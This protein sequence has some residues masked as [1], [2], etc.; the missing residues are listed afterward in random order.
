MVVRHP[1][2]VLIHFTIASVPP[3]L[4]SISRRVSCVTCDLLSESHNTRLQRK[5]INENKKEIDLKE[6]EVDEETGGSGV[7]DS[8]EE[9]D[10][11]KK[12]NGRKEKLKTRKKKRGKWRIRYTGQ[13]R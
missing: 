11:S 12:K 6:G 5:R 2:V 8:S 3:S 7:G 13:R 9:M 1:S 4:S 10:S